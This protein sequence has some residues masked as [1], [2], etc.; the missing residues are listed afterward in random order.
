VFASSRAR[1]LEEGLNISFSNVKYESIADFVGLDPVYK[2]EDA[3]TFDIFRSRIPTPLFKK[4][5][6]DIDDM[7]IQYGP[8]E[9]HMTEEATSR[10]F[11][12]VKLIH[13]LTRLSNCAIP[14]FPSLGSYVFVYL[15]KS[16]RIAY[17]GS[18]Y[19]RRSRRILLHLVWFHLSSCYRSQAQNHGKPLKCYCSGYRRM[20]RSVSWYK[21]LV[22]VFIELEVCSWTNSRGS[23]SLVPVFGILCDGAK[24]EFFKFQEDGNSYTFSRGCIPG[25]P[26][27]FRIGLPISDPSLN[28]TL[29]LKELRIICETIFDIM[30]Q[31]YVLSLEAFRDRSVER[32]KK[33]NPPRKGLTKWEDALKSARSALDKFRRADESYRWAYGRCQFNHSGRH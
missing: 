20:W 22:L 30:L 19:H 27:A 1:F 13:I 2:F 29:F 3:P 17:R 16:P 4:I 21:F 26:R 6:E 7:V 5:V 23:P 14:D 24:F 12:P 28:P 33:F 32:G 11:S 9:Q 18:F 25:D 8:P 31:A 15:Q 10:F